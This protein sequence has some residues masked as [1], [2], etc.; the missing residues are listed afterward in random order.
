MYQENNSSII[1]GVMKI[2]YVNIF[3]LVTMLLSFF[4]CIKDKP[5]E[6]IQNQIGVDSN[7]TGNGM[8]IINEGGY[9]ASNSSIS[10]LNF[11]SGIV[12]QDLFFETNQYPLGDICQSMRI[13]GSKAFIVVNNSGKVEV[14]N[15]FNLQH[16]A[17][18]NGLVS[19]RYILPISNSKAYITDLYSNYISV[20]DLN[21]YQIIESIPCPTGTEQMLEIFGKVY[22]TNIKTNYLYVINTLTDNVSDSIFIGKT[23]IDILQDKNGKL[24]ISCAKAY[25]ENPYGSIIKL[26][27]VNDEI[28]STYQFPNQ[29][30]APFRMCF[31]PT[32]DTLYYINQN[33]YRM[34][35]TESALPLNAFINQGDRYFYGLGIDPNSGIICVADANGFTGT[36]SVYRYSSNGVFKDSF[37]AGIGTSGLYFD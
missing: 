23:T 16:I 9:G 8:Y 27:P 22:V 20:V 3:V 19:P 4:S 14:C 6:F 21:T 36:G 33:V 37:L 26:N 30:D 2:K 25:P 31:N 10:F 15:K 34:G 1:F 13:I 32:Y 12:T 11:N 35:I 28:E 7:Q 5:P 24:W 17:A 18:I 29:L